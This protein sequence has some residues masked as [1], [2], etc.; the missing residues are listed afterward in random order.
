MALRT[1]PHLP[2]VIVIEPPT[3][4]E[5]LRLFKR[6]GFWACLVVF[7]AFGALFGWAAHVKHEFNEANAAHVGVSSDPAGARIKIDGR[8]T[9]WTPTVLAVSP[10]PHTLRLEHSGDGSAVYQLGTA[11][12]TTSQLQA[13]LWSSAPDLV[14]LRPVLPGT[15]V[16]NAQFLAGGKV[17]LTVA[18]PSG[19]QQAW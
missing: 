9:G 8:D 19:L 15:R 3:R 13:K 11:S 1:S 17:V 4:R 18:F 5:L 7:A 16:V 12:G 2:F 10:G 6:P 14:P